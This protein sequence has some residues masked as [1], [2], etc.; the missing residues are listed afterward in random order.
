[1]KNPL[2]VLVIEDD[3]WFAEQHLRVLREAG[4]T[5]RMAA[6]GITAIEEL[7]NNAPD[8]IILDIFLPGPNA[9]VLLHEIQSYVDLAKIPVIICSGSALDIPKREL[10]ILGVREVL[11]KATMRPDEVAIAIKRALL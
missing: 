11:D 3:P 7:D 10:A 8:A 4:F 6:D 2:N 9:F 1:M 5:V